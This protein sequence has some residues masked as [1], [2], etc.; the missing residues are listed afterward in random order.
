MSYNIEIGGGLGKFAGLA[1]RVGLMGHSSTEYKV[2]RL[3]D[4]IGEVFKK[5][6]IAS[7][8]TAGSQAAKAIYQDPE[9][10]G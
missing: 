7:D 10:S 4:A 9:R 1:W 8:R 3:L 5:Y 2:Y 6:G